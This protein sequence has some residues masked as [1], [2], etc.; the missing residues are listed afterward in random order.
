MDASIL[1]IGG[2]T[3]GASTAW[4]L[5]SRG[6]SDITVIDRKPFPSV[7]SAA[8][9][10]NKIIRTEYDEPLYSDMAIE[11]IKAW[12][13]P[14]FKGIFHET[15]W[16]VT[17]SGDP[18]A[19]QR[20]RRSY[21]NLVD[22]GQAEGVEFVE[23][24]EDIVKHVPQLANAKGIAE[25]KG[26]YNPQAGWAHARKA[27]EKVGEEAKKL[28]VKF[29]G[30][31]DGQ[32]TGIESAN[33]KISGIKVASGK[34]HTASRYI[35]CTGAASPAV[36]PEL[37][38]HLW[39]KCWTLG[40]IELTPAEI[41]QFR[42]MP[43]VDNHELGFFFEADEDKGW[44]KICNEFQGYQFRT[45]KYEDGD[46]TVEFSVPRYASEHPGEGIPE[47][48]M[49]G[50][51]RLIDIALPQFSGREIKGASDTADRHFLI[52]KHPAYPDGELLLATGDSGHAFKF[53]PT[54]G[55]YIA[56]AFEDKERG[57]KKV[58]RWTDRPWSH[59]DSRPGD[60]VKDLREVGMG[61]GDTESRL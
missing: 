36:L 34:I 55:S 6:Y 3:W 54:I 12:R 1:I 11:A 18:G 39:S 27:L 8:Y 29:I 20:L 60:R 51:N 14:L 19:A 57:L 26:Y 44:M 23:S 4:H 61:V 32:M 21:Q 58:W 35:L 16:L 48:A 59:D 17:T 2:G 25:W 42:N 9:D 47:E 31:P 7:D 56:D 37:G 15:G 49:K 24:E 46:S 43:V 28:G 33:N 40:H 10:L 53:L 45:G 30:G 50:I 13:Q 52:D 22:R 41:A 5:A 38:P